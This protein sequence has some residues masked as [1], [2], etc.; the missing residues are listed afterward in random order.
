MLAADVL[1][2]RRNVEPLLS[3]LPWLG[4]EVLLA[5]PGRPA[6]RAF[7]DGA[8]ERWAVTCTPADALSRGGVYRLRTREY[9]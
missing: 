8:A 5:D 2:E 3:L 4:P 6:L 9:A 7:L 1:Y